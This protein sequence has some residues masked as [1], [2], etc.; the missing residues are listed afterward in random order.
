MQGIYLKKRK[1][2]QEREREK[3]KKI[4]WDIGSTL[5]TIV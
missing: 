2:E 4:M 3:K 1:K 5:P